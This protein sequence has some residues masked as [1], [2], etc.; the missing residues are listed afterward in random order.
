MKNWI[1][2]V[3]RYKMFGWNIYKYE[4]IYTKILNI[5]DNHYWQY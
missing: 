4:Q 5:A 2:G 3:E 1:R